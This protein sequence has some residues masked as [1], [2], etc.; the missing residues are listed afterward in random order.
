MSFERI[1]KEFRFSNKEKAH[2]L[3][4]S[5][6]MGI[7]LSFRMW[8]DTSL[9][10]NQGLESLMIMTLFSFIALFVHFSAQ[11]LYGI[12]KGIKTT[13][14][15]NPYALGIGVYF[16]LLFNGLIYLISPGYMEVRTEREKRV[17][18]FRYRATFKEYGYMVVMGVLANLFIAGIFSGLME[19]LFVFNFMKVN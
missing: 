18:K 13:Y 5:F 14:K 10:L 11:K 3:I 1:K 19:N 9:D 16:A 6:L 4:V 15:L 2:C 7:I 17:G 12:V 8:G